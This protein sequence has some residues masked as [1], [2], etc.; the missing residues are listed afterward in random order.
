MKT[1]R[2]HNL[3]ARRGVAAI[4][5]LIFVTLFASLAVAMASMSDGNLKIAHNQHKA[6]TARTTAESG[7]EVVRFWLNRVAMPGTVAASN[8]FPSLYSSLQN[9]ITTNGITNINPVYSATT[10]TVA[11]VPLDSAAQQSFAATITKIDDDNFRLDVTGTAGQISRTIRAGYSFSQ[12]ANNVFDY[13][14][15]TKGPLS[16]SGNIDLDGVNVAVEAS[17][18][19]ESENHDVALSI[20]GN[21]QI[22]GD[23]SITNPDATVD[24]Q[25]GQA[26][27]GGETGDDAIENHVF[28]GVPPTEF[29]VPNA[30]HF[31]QYVQ[32]TFDPATTPTSNVT[33]ENILIPA[34]SG[35]ISF[36][37]N[38]VILGVMYIETPN[39][40]Q[41]T[42]NTSIT[43]IIVGDGDLYDDSAVNQIEFQG[44]VDSASV[45]ELP[46]EQ[47][48]NLCDETGTF[49]MAPGFHVSFGG[50][51]ES[52]NGAIAANGV[53]FSGNAGGIINGS[54][55]NY[56]DEPMNL[57]GNSD[58]FFNRSGTTEVPA[59]F[60]PEII[61]QYDAGSYTE[62]ANS[63]L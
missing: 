4:M 19:I 40:I 56:A 35:P 12:R 9:D 29:P 61:L 1:Y 48:G 26:G 63:L 32:N 27:I 52:L 30:G 22:A 17:V 55:I 49:V 28:T 41:F 23:V 31:S 2:K 54:V 36:G 39:V 50:D 11:A 16:L 18:Y 38:V 20:I 59:G 43:G 24:L 7:L 57:S 14:V 60:E 42:G 25:G 15:A 10:I 44:S 37:G 53:G 6:A 47:F 8:R 3:V 34:N 58:L 62:V 13:G 45:S 5:A 21:S 46:R 33:L 51:F